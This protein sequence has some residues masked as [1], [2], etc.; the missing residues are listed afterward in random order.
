MMPL[1]PA[2]H[3]APRTGQEAV[4]P[5]R[6][7]VTVSVIVPARNEEAC[8]GL[9]LESLLAQARQGT[10]GKP[11]LL[12]TG[13]GLLFEIIVVDDHSIDR[14]AAIAAADTRVRVL[15]AP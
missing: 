6:E 10:T 14:T 15:V 8:L 2:P 4:C 9:C 1:K 3:G 13:Q 5:R 11:G 7:T 12:D